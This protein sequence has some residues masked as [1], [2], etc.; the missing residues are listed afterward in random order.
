MTNRDRATQH[1]TGS[2]MRATVRRARAARGAQSVSVMSV[3]PERSDM[4][5]FTNE[6]ELTMSTPKVDAAKVDAPA[7]VAVRAL[8]PAERKAIVARVKTTQGTIKANSKALLAD[9]I[10]LCKGI[11]AEDFAAKL[12]GEIGAARVGRVLTRADN[13]TLIKSLRD[14]AREG[15][16]I[17]GE[18]VAKVMGISTG[19]VSTL[20][21]AEFDAMGGEIETVSPG[22]TAG[23]KTGVS[24]LDTITAELDKA[25]AKEDSSSEEFLA[26][27]AE[28]RAKIQKA[29]PGGHA[30]NMGGKG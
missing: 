15:G 20:N 14:A 4:P 8:T 21:K 16:K 24:I 30:G 18:D 5:T 13:A 3:M 1:S 27:L 17:N 10:A 26:K 25:L 23:G 19:Q 11:K 29:L 9:V 7:T 6:T 28:L 2:A 22:N 12:G